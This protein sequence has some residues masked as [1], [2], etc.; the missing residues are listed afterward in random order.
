MATQ[1]LISNTPAS[2][3]RGGTRLNLESSRLWI[4]FDRYFH[5]H[6]WLQLDLATVLI[7]QGI[8]DPNL[9]IKSECL[10]MRR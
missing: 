5:F 3:A 1:T 9:F 2:I 7:S 4:G 8:L 10:Y 6:S